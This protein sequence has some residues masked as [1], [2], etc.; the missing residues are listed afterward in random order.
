MARINCEDS[1]FLIEIG[2][3]VRRSLIK[4]F[5]NY[6]V[7]TIEKR[8]LSA[9]DPVLFNQDIIEGEAWRLTNIVISRARLDLDGISDDLRSSERSASEIVAEEIESAVSETELEYLGDGPHDEL[10]ELNMLIE[11]ASG[12]FSEIGR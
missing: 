1:R 6:L 4:H 10:S 5:M 9:R 12:H 11:R 7:T 3:G 2:D 8:G